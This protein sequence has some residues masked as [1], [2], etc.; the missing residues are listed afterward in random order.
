MFLTFSIILMPPFIAYDFPFVTLALFA[1]ICI[2][3]Y[4]HAY[5]KVME[6]SDAQSFSNGYKEGI[7][8]VEDEIKELSKLSDEEIVERVKKCANK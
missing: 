2:L 7:K 6:K 5:K 1:I 3:V 4:K 8:C